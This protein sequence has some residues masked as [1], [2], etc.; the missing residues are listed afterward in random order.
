MN[1]GRF[2]HY[3]PFYTKLIAPRPV[4]VWLPDAV[5][6]DTQERYPV[7]YMHDGQ[8]LFD[9]GTAF[10]GVDWGMVGT[11]HGLIREGVIPPV[12]VVGIWS[13]TARAREYG[14]EKAVGA[15]ANSAER[16]RYIRDFGKPMSDY[17]LR[18]I[19]NELKPVIDRTFPTRTDAAGTCIMGSSFGGLVSLYAVCEYPL[20]FGGAG[21]LSSHWPAAG[22]AMIP[23]LADHLPD[24]ETHRIYFDYGTEA[25]DAQ[26]EPYQ[27]RAD[28]LMRKGGYQEGDNWITRK[29]I[30]EEH[31]ESAW[32]K[33]V[34]IPIRFL[35]AQ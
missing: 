27:V 7:L 35:L 12:I 11:V 1:F 17:Y 6:L 21:C 13:A 3:K 25:L 5:K 14:P 8:N 24:P 33:R 15:Y 20:I 28:E 30:G 34:H 2:E 10:L 4:D 18:F 23:Y 22:G 26:Y 9:P 16:K 19:V 31:S 32:R 29:F